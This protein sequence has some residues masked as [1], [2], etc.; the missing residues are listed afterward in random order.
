MGRAKD[1]MVDLEK[2]PSFATHEKNHMQNPDTNHHKC[3]VLSLYLQ[4]SDSNKG[5][6]FF[7]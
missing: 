3:K 2:S 4:T 1:V 7:K 5:S 6:G